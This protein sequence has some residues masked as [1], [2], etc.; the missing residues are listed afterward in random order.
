MV[1]VTGGC[2]CGEIRYEAR[3]EIL[4][5]GLC[6][7][8]VC[9]R[10]AGGGPNYALLLSP[11]EISVIEGKTSVFRS[12][13][14]SGAMVERHFCGNCGAHLFG[15]G[16]AYADTLRIK[17]GSLDNPSLFQPMAQLWTSSAQ[18]W[19]HLNPNLQTFER[20]PPGME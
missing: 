20:N 9:Q 18:S 1:S 5:A 11:F 8:S 13:G 19:H 15:Q 2:L 4:A 17:A 14:G 10:L 12:A 16:G 6:Y 7:C 3:G